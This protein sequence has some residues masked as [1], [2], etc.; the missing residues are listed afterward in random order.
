MART[1]THGSGVFAYH[2]PIDSFKYGVDDAVIDEAVTV[3]SSGR[4]RLT[5]QLADHIR[6]RSGQHESAIALAPFAS[7]SRALA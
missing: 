7:H 4:L 2:L 5:D 6:T 3:F 1:G